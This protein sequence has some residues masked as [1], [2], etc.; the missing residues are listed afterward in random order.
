[1]HQIDADDCPYLAAK[2]SYYF[3]LAVF[4][5]LVFLAAV[6]GFLPFTNLWDRIVTWMILYVPSEMRKSLLLTIIDLTRG[7]T[8]FLSFGIIGTTWAATSGFVSLMESLSTVYGVKE[9]RGFWKKRV[10]AVLTLFVVSG[11][12]LGSFGLMAAGHWLG[13]QILGHGEV[14]RKFIVLW[15]L[16]RWITSLV[17]VFLAIDLM[18]YALPN[19]RRRWRW[20]SPGGTVAVAGLL[21]VSASFNFYVRHFSLYGKTYDA[22]MVF[23]V[24]TVWIYLASFILLVGAE[25]NSVL[26]EFR[27]AG[28]KV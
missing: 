23:I 8:G 5:F 18:D 15:E 14:A 1:V 21:V 17:L 10:I 16:G 9:T 12:F 27:R 6:V 22:L 19:K 3:V 28:A 2:M 24:L 4:P 26:E 7:R 11:F 20:F 13:Q 25:T